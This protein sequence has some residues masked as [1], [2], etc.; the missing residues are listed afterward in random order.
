MAKLCI[1]K[2]L[3]GIVFLLSVYVIEGK[4]CNEGLPWVTTH[5]RGEVAQ[6]NCWVACQQRHGMDVK[7]SCRDIIGIPTQICWCTW[8]C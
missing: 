4:E 7:A 5:C 8:P 3:C 1:T 2:S 6:G